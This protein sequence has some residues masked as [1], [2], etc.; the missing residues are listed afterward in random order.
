MSEVKLWNACVKNTYPF[1]VIID[2]LGLKLNDK[3]KYFTQACNVDIHK[4]ILRACEVLSVEVDV[5]KYTSCPVEY[6]ISIC[7]N[8]RITRKF[9]TSLSIG[10]K[11]QGSARLSFVHEM[12]TLPKDKTLV[13]K[14]IDGVPITDP[15]D[16]NMTYVEQFGRCYS[17][18]MNI[19]DILLTNP[20][21]F[22]HFSKSGVA[23]IS[24]AAAK[25]KKFF[26]LDLNI[27]S[28]DS[29]MFEYMKLVRSETPTTNNSKSLATKHVRK[30][31][32]SAL[33]S[34]VWRTHFTTIDGECLC[35][36][37]AITIEN[38]EC[39]H[40]TSVANGGEDVLSNLLP[41]CSQCNKS[42]GTEDFYSYKNRVFG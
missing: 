30:S 7:S 16:L 34:R 25:T 9:L 39:A 23:I 29:K 24:Q 21:K 6:F 35:C 42:M 11:D 41:S 3:T 10:S 38:W 36:G 31:I 19:R 17:E 33:R 2:Q 14:T 4:S 37:C 22:V 5:E 8:D 12:L 13:V 18:C 27:S 26:D 40:V 28:T 32:P 15:I 20:S 1:N